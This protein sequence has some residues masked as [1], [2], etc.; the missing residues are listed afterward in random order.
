MPSSTSLS[1]ILLLDSYT[2][3]CL[4]QRVKL[5]LVLSKHDGL[6]HVVNIINVFQRV[7]VQPTSV[8]LAFHIN[9]RSLSSSK[10]SSL[11]CDLLIPY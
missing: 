7:T 9:T 1:F 4:V 11:S 8:T 5:T 2:R 3:Y 6:Q 10:Y